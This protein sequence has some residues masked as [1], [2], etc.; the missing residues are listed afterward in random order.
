MASRPEDDT[1]RLGF[2]ERLADAELFLLLAVEPEDD[3]DGDRLSPQVFPLAEGPFVL[4]F[5]RE[6]RLAAFTG[7]PAPYARLS[8]RVLA[9]MLEGQGTGLGVNLGAPSE[10]LLP[11]GAVDWLAATL[12]RAPEEVEAAPEE[13]RRPAGLPEV[14]IAGLTTKLAAAEGLARF[15][16]LAAVTYRGGRQGHLLAFTGTR[17]GAE[18]ALARAASEALIFSG[19]EAGEIDVTYIRDSDPMAARLAKV[20]LRF[21]IP[22]VSAAEA[23]T[24]PG[25]DP[26]RPPR[27][28]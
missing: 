14:V 1:A 5:D 9:G 3:T 10:H 26:N 21:D 17:P 19:I 27:L 20:A 18:A 24:A 28:R 8:G 11:A 13:L 6:Q 23:P 7:H 2:Y 15:A 16:W 22:E 4:A 25:L 12:A